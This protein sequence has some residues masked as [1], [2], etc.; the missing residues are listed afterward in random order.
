[1]SAPFSFPRKF[2]SRRRFAGS[3]QE[4]VRQGEGQSVP[5]PP[6]VPDAAIPVGRRNAPRLRLSLPARLISLHDTHR[7][8]LIDLSC[9]GAQVG[10]AEPLKIEETAI[11]EIAGQEIFCEVVRVAIGENGGAN[12]L[13]FDPPLEHADVLDMRRYGETYLDQ[14]L[15]G[16]R[17]EVRAWVEGPL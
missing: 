2:S 7:C 4:A 11:L 6:A 5:A 8:I 17:S 14:E 1:M 9:T 15:R 10:M 3:F 13:L 12:G 16:F